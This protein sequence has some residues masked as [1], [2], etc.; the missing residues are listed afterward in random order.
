MGAGGGG[1]GEGEAGGPV[2]ALEGLGGGAEAR[3]DGGGEVYGATPAHFDLGVA[4]SRD[5]ED[6]DQFDVEKANGD[7]G[8][9][10]RYWSHGG[11]AGWLDFVEERNGILWPAFNRQG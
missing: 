5:L 7:C 10:E 1:G 9:W 3:V 2:G 4:G 8:G 11:L 6:G